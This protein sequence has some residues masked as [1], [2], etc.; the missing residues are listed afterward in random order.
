MTLIACE[1]PCT[2]QNMHRRLNKTLKSIG[3]EHV[4]RLLAAESEKISD[5]S[6]ETSRRKLFTSPTCSHN[7]SLSFLSESVDTSQ[8]SKGTSLLDS[9][10]PLVIEF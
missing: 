2:C 10:S 8:K 9:V 1:K 7:K 4:T 6:I 3:D 5:E